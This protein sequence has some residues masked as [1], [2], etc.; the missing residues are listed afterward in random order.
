MNTY[1]GKTWSGWSQVA[2]GGLT[3]VGLTAVNYKGDL[4]LFGK[5]LSDRKAYVNKYNGKAWTGWSEVPGGGYTDAAMAATSAGGK[6]YLFAR[7]IK[8]RGMYAN[9][10][11]NSS[12]SGWS[13]PRHR[14]DAPRTGR[15]D[16]RRH[17]VGHRRR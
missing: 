2:G 10:L 7:G 3:D 9:A 1:N 14:H 4:Y 6:L 13:P 11:T 15:D 5:G 8:D 12:W 16:E 17:G